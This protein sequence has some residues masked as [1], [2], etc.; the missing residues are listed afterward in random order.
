MTQE[1]MATY[2]ETALTLVSA[3][4]Q[5]AF[6][7]S[8]PPPPP[9]WGL[10]IHS[11][12]R[13]IIPLKGEKRIVAAFDGEIQEK[14]FQPGDILFC[15]PTGWS[16][17]LWTSDHEMLSVTYYDELLRA[18]HIAHDGLAA[19]PRGPDV[20]HHASKPINETGRHLIRTLTLSSATPGSL[21]EGWALCRALLRL[22]A[23]D[24]RHDRKS[25]SGKSLFLWACVTKHLQENWAAE[26]TRES[27]AA[28]FRIHPNHLSRLFKEHAGTTFNAYV[29]G[30]K[31]ERAEEMLKSSQYSIDEIAL[32][33]G[34]KYTSYFIRMFKRHHEMPPATYRR[35]R[36]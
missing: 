32:H 34:Y 24:L 5:V 28:N 20:F 11:S 18:I 26:L 33:C 9:E 3:S 19:P 31:M 1:I 30:L 6:A 13:L 10:Y 7:M 22:T 14:A 8:H 2:V 23:Q 16:R 17:E 29:T 25:E 35:M 15:V 12:P 27:V 36:T 4:S 21:E